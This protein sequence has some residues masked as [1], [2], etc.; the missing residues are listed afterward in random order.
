[1]RKLKIRLLEL[2]IIL[3]L[4]LLF[5]ILFKGNVFASTWQ[6]VWENTVIHVPLYDELNKY[7]DI[8][9]ATLYR[10]GNKLDCNIVY[11]KEGDWLHFLKD[12]NTNKVGTY[13]VWYKAFE[14]DTYVPGTCNGYKCLITFIV[15]DKTP[16]EIGVHLGEIKQRRIALND[17]EKI[18]EII[19][20]NISTKDNYSEVELSFIHNVDL[21]TVGRYK[22]SVFATD[23]SNNV[24]NAEFFVDVFDDHYPILY[25]NAPNDYLVISRANNVDIKGYFKAIDEIDDDITDKII[26]P[27]MDLKTL[28]KK[29]YEIKITNSGG[30]TTTKKII[31]E[32]IDDVV[33]TINLVSNVITLDYLTNIDNIN[34]GKY[35]LSIED[36]GKVDYDK[37]VV[38]HNLENKVGSYQIY[39]HY[40][41]GFNEAEASLEVKFISFSGPK[42][43]VSEVV[44]DEG[45][46]VSLYDYFEISDPSDDKVFSSV[47]IL[48]ENVNYEKEGTYYASV[49]AINSS[50][51]STTKKIRIIVNKKYNNLMVIV[52]ILT[53][54]LALLLSVGLTFLIIF[55]YKKYKNKKDTDISLNL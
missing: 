12:V 30:N 8:P 2:G 14:Y 46:Y 25:F 34:F 51:I 9:K 31:I 24:T 54:F 1:M 7:I 17:N 13:Y 50:G 15:E 40:S 44:I 18:D 26:F 16:P 42:I 55:F 6:Y 4:T 48:D 53:V 47:K 45:E 43:T 36:D 20:N 22:V 32:I 28:G 23:T 35:V 10:D 11:L 41:D 38:R 3:I 49:Y 29:E 52:I 21:S 27:S 37:L 19:K 5:G 39:Y 33:P